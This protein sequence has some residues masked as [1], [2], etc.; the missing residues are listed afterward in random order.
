MRTELSGPTR[1]H[2]PLLVVPLVVKPASNFLRHRQRCHV[3]TL[4]PRNVRETFTPIILVW[5]L[6]FSERLA[7]SNRFHRL[8]ASAEQARACPA[9]EGSKRTELQGS[10]EMSGTPWVS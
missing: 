1:A 2:L 8:A 4:L 5:D 3:P 10:V 9:G 6:A 7:F